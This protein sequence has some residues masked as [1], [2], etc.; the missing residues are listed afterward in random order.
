MIALISPSCE[1]DTQEHPRI[2]R[3]RE[4]NFHS[5]ST[6]EIVVKCFHHT[7]G[8]W[9]VHSVK[10]CSLRISQDLQIITTSDFSML[11]LFPQLLFSLCCAMLTHSM[12]RARIEFVRGYAILKF[13]CIM[14]VWCWNSVIEARRYSPPM[15]TGSLNT[16]FLNWNLKILKEVNLNH[17]SA[18]AVKIC[19]TRSSFCWLHQSRP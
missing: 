19:H 14:F 3:K 11:C 16:N 5:A 17:W 13:L 15:K 7:Q 2:L 10:K 12:W 1:I 18:R 4:I 6:R 9:R 8:S